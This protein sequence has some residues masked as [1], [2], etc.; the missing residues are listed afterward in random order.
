MSQPAYGVWVI[1]AGLVALVAVSVSAI[2]HFGTATDV[3]TAVS[4][5]SGVIAALA[6]GYF[7]VR[8]ATV[9]QQKANE[10]PTNRKGNM[11]RVR[12]PPPAS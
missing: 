3:V 5:I 6:G 12:T 1:V 4:P 7:G 11:S 2:F 9:A 8:G 10:V